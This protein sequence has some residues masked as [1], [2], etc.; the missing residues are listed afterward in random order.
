MKNNN[1]LITLSLV[2]LSFVCTECFVKPYFIPTN[3]LTLRPMTRHSFSDVARALP[4]ADK[5]FLIH[6]LINHIL[7]QKGD[8][9]L[10]YCYKKL[11]YTN[12]THITT[13]VDLDFVIK[14]HCHNLTT[15]QLFDTIEDNAKLTDC[16][17]HIYTLDDMKK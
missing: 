2:F 14:K 17:M 12:I 5:Y 8:L 13:S 3:K 9:L 6:S 10:D 7:L 16:Y 11:N 1:K 4:L 15:L